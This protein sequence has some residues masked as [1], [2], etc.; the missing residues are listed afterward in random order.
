MSPTL[1]R[2]TTRVER[3]NFVAFFS[4]SKCARGKTL[5]PRT[6][7]EPRHFKA[8]L[9][10]LSAFTSLLRQT[11]D[12]RINR[13]FRLAGIARVLLWPQNG[14]P[15]LS[16]EGALCRQLRNESEAVSR[17]NGRY[18]GG[19][20]RNDYQTLHGCT[21]NVGVEAR[22]YSATVDAANAENVRRHQ[23]HQH[24]EARTPSPPERLHRSCFGS[25]SPK[26]PDEFAAN[27]RSLVYCLSQTATLLTVCP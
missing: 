3:N 19:Q 16:R 23:S 12:K 13:S 14:Q 24:D 4:L 1:H 26:V 9:R 10:H 15:H 20:R 22:R 27:R 17:E 11:V 5:Q 6:D 25:D 18:R 21:R 8:S 7:W 2:R